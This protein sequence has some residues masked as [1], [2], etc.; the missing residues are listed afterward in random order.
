MWKNNV[1]AC[2]TNFAREIRSLS[3]VTHI[4]S[5]H[6]VFIEESRHALHIHFPTLYSSCTRTWSLR[7]L[8]R[9]FKFLIAPNARKGFNYIQCF[10]DNRLRRKYLSDERGEKFFPALGTELGM[11]RLTYRTSIR[12]IALLRLIGV[13]ALISRSRYV[14]AAD[15]TKSSRT[16]TRVRL[17]ECWQ[18]FIN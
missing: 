11:V 6:K 9:T 17:H 13:I 12:L 2:R 8:S 18:P 7:G 4:L 5:T 1:K 10:S 15:D 14:T 16:L 3:V